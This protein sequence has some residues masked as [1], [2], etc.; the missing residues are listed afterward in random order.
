MVELP[1]DKNAID[2]KWVF[3]TMFAT[4]RNLLKHKARFVAKVYA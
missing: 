1:E 2:L 4:N 3:K